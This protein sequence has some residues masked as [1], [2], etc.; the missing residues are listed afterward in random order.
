MYVGRPKKV[1]GSRKKIDMVVWK[2]FGKMVGK[3]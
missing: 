2:D 1:V 3:E